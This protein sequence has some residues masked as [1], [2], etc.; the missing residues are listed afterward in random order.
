V[1]S[2]TFILVVLAIYAVVQ[3]SPVSFTAPSECYLGSGVNAGIILGMAASYFFYIE[4]GFSKKSSSID[5][6]NFQGIPNSNVNPSSSRNL[7][8]SPSQRTSQS[9]LAHESF[10]IKSQPDPL[11]V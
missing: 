10:E 2:F 1:A 4:G 8:N 3:T 6:G 11:S 5:T 9:I 7:H